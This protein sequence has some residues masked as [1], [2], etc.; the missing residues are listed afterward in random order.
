MNHSSRVCVCVCTVI[1]LAVSSANIL[2]YAFPR[3][4]SFLVVHFMIKIH[5][6][7]IFLQQVAETLARRGKG[8]DYFSL[9][10]SLH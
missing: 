4:C 10:F 5:C 7:C 2:L 6:C 8:V 1:S 3:G 9:D